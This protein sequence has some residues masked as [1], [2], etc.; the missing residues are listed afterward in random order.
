MV[1]LDSRD[2]I[3]SSVQIYC[4]ASETLTTTDVIPFGTVIQRIHRRQKS[5]VRKC[6]ELLFEN[7]LFPSRAGNASTNRDFIPEFP[8]WRRINNPFLEVRKSSLCM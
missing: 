7:S 5:E 6:L 1:T 2:L 4:E 3:C 8:W